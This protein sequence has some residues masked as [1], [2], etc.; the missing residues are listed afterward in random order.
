MEE[1]DPHLQILTSEEV[2][3]K[4]LDTIPIVSVSL[5]FSVSGNFFELFRG[6]YKRNYLSC[7]YYVFISNFRCL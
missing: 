3:F 6:L 4:K 7:K 1:E 2:Y 5:I